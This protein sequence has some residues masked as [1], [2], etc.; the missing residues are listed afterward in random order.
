ME[1]EHKGRLLLLGLGN[2]LMGDEGV[3][4]HLAQR[5]EKRTDLPPGVDVQEGGTAGFQ[6]TEYFTGYPVII[7]IDATLDEH[8]PGT[9]RLLKPRFSSEF[10]KALST[11]DI[12]LKDLLD[13]LTLLGKMPE[14][15]LFVMSVNT[16]QPMHIGLSPEVE[17]AL[18]ELER[19]V[20]E[21]ARTLVN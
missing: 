20:V 11:H 18:P 10:P 7:L 17:A 9:I 14:I 6:L 3:G 21:L 2:L 1:T 5:L 16:L 19:Q 13:G 12:G 15:H 8:P 4:V